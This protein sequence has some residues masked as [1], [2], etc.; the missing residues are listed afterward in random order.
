MHVFSKFLLKGSAALCAFLVG[1]HG[2]PAVARIADLDRIRALIPEGVHKVKAGET[3]STIARAHGL[4]WRELARIN[5][6]LNPN[7]IV[8]GAELRLQGLREDM[9]RGGKDLRRMVGA[10]ARVAVS[11]MDSAVDAAA[12]VPDQVAGAGGAQDNAVLAARLPVIVEGRRFG[13]VPVTATVS[14][15]LTISPSLLA[16]SLQPILSNEAQGLLIGLGSAQVPVSTLAELGYLVRLD[17]QTLSV[18]VYVPATQRAL[19]RFSLL[20]MDQYPE[21]EQ[22][23]PSRFAGGLTGSLAVTDNFE[24][25]SDPAVQLGFFG[26]ANFGGLRG[27]NVDYGGVFDARDGQTD[28]RRDGIVAFVD[29]PEHAVRYSA[30]DLLPAQP[31]L[32]GSAPILGL[33]VQRNYQMLQPLRLIR[34]TGRRSFLL[35][36]PATVEVYANNVLIN[37]FAAGPGPVDLADIAVANLTNDITIVVEDALGRREL[38][39]FSL[40]NDVNLLGAGLDEFS[41]SLGVMRDINQGGFTY[42]EDW[43]FSGYY[44]R[45]VSEQLTVGAHAA[46]TEEFQNLGGSVAFAGLG[47][48]ALVEGAVSNSA[49]GKE[50]F[51]ASAA[52]RG[53]NFLGQEANDV[54]SA[55]IEYYSE[56]FATLSDPNSLIDER[57]RV[58]LDYRFEIDENTAVLL[59][60]TY[61]DRHSLAGADRFLTAGVSR[62]FGRLQAS[63]T[64]RVGEDA[65]GR[66]DAGVF[67]SLSQV[68][69]ARTVASAS[70]DS[71]SET[72]RVEVARSRRLQ[73]PD[74]S[75]RVGWQG[76]PGD[77]EAFGQASYL[78]SRFEADA[79]VVGDLE[80]VGSSRGQTA[81]VRVQSGVAFADGNFALGRDPGRGFYM[82]RRHP[83]LSG[84]EL[85]VY[86]GRLRS[87]PLASSGAFGPAVAP[88]T[89][90]Y[91][92]TELSI[93]VN[94]APPGY[95]VG[96]TRFVVLPGARSGVVIE[97]G[98]EAYRWRLATLRIAGEP[99]N[100]AYGELINL[101]TGEREAFF[102]NAAGRASFASLTPGEY[103]IRLAERAFRSR[104]TVLNDDDPFINMGIINL[105]R[106]P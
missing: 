89:S 26:F 2:L 20:D 92:P 71:L 43:A 19:E 15:V 104:F 52:Y 30:G 97:V 74:F 23:Y 58:A 8:V 57:W 100:L 17:P 99:V 68:F 37:R 49:L 55:R 28:F 102:T 38:D 76:R 93:D 96:D 41:V 35:E 22:V 47:G 5:G 16:T 79:R 73:T 31:A 46:A 24:D 53:G 70:Y 29:H 77:Q 81:T 62:R 42:S 61:A 10:E 106:I 66:E 90:A 54:L 11:W 50:G 69:G 85:Q 101:E 27:V 32:G 80:S 82:V 84:A 91:R 18:A 36:Q 98:S 86:Q 64:G 40:A 39:S 48:V 87:M 78:G 12:D 60:A 9:E 72:G 63:L 65:F 13:S 1:L 33:T 103:E 75:Y 14:E 59:G 44:V 25:T 7:L 4:D 83:S 21:A 67:V 56:D 94:G 3:L 45:G 6:I 105:E 51:A 88:V 34:P 95:D